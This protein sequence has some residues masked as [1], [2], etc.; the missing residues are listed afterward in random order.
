MRLK[1]PV[2][3]F[4]GAAGG[5][6]QSN[7]AS[8]SGVISDAQGAVMQG[9]RVTMINAQT[10]VPAHAASN[11]AGFYAIPNL[12]VGTYTLTVEREGFRRYVREG[13]ALSTGQTLGLDVKM[14]VGALAETVTVSGD[15]PLVETRTSD[16]TQLIEAKSIAD[17]PLGNRHT[18]N[19][20]NLTGAAVFVTYPNAPGNSNPSFTLAG[21]RPQ[22]QMFWIDGGSG[23]N[24]RLGAGQINL[25]PPVDTV[26]EIKVLSNN[27]SA[28]YGGSAGGIIVET[29]RS[30]T[31][32]LHGSA[33]EYLRNNAMDAPGFFAPVQNGAK[34]TP[35]LRYNVF[36]GTAGGPVRRDKTFFFA[37]Y[38]GQ[39]LRTGG[40]D[41]LTVPTALQRAGDFSQTFNAAGKVIPIYDPATSPR[42]QFPGNVIP[43]TRLDAVGVKILSFYPQANRAADNATGA[44]NFRANYVSGTPADFYMGKIDHN[45]S[46]RDR[47]TGRY[48]RNGGTNFNTSAFPDAGADPR[49]HAENQQQ[50]VYGNWTRTINPTSVNDF[51]FTYIYRVFHDLSAG[52]GGGYPAKMGL[53]GVPD[54]AFPRF[55]IAGFSTLGTN[56]QERR[57]FPIEQQQFVDNFSKVKG[58]HALKF[59]FEARRSRNHEFNLPTV[60]GDF[61]FATQPT[62]LAGN[63]ATGYGLASLLLGFPSNFAE[64]QT[65]ELDRSS[66]YL[67]AFA[68]DDWTVSP[69]LTV[70]LGLRWE[71]DTPIVD[72]RNRMNGFDPAQINPVSGTPGVVK[73]M[74]VN[75]FRTTPYDL[76]WNNFGPRFGFAWKPFGASGTVIRGGYGIFYAHPFDSGQPNTAALGFSTS[77]Q[78]STP[79]NGITAPFFLRDGVPALPSAPLL[80]DS[81]GAAPLGKAVNTAVTYYEASRATGYAQQFNLG[82]QHELPVQSV[83]ELTVLGNLSRKLANANLPLAQIP[84][85]ILGPA[86]QS[87]VDRP[88]PQFNGVTIIAPPLG[89]SNYY[90]G[91]LR[92]QKRYAHGLNLGGSYT[93]AK[94]L[95]NTSDPGSSLGA[96]A[97]PYSDFYNRRAD[98]GYGQ[99]DIRHRFSFN[100]VYELPFGEGRHWL[101]KG[102]AGKIVG[103]WSLANVTTVQSGPPATVTTQT[104]TTNAFSAGAQRADVSRDPNL[105]PGSRTVAQWFDTAAFTQPAQFHFGNQGVGLV[106]GP[107][108][109]NV[110]FSL[111]RELR[112]SERMRLQ[113]RGE[114]I[115]A[116]NRTNLGVPGHTFGAPGFGVISGLSLASSPRQVQVGARIAF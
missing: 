34:V 70:N 41:A 7:L 82:V 68:Q 29:T 52:L 100:A 79:D 86:H 49:N 61:S 84:P 108:L 22:S 114:F 87:Q 107:G 63:A 3:L 64:N 6:A 43:P 20:I 25:D 27:N 56:A 1:I 96:N 2:L 50:Y 15:V 4:L 89:V 105:A 44:N 54:N 31:N 80:N 76:D 48:L 67:A 42:T 17:L 12:A 101:G 95:D 19:V 109:I 73:F 55:T 60:S 78:L 39:R 98:Y 99:N 11:D 33:Y 113:L 91:L 23:Q 116:L 30:G 103:D 24:M 58:R 35:E 66:W 83:V 69:S 13:M 90:A 45:L 38:E 112:F 88:F 94:F 104:N 28:E 32:H 16:V 26:E 85:Q 36:G 5:L 18:L 115:N 97:G 71:V 110:D 9:A 102:A 37:A 57:Q 106:R 81:Y 111:Q 53:K 47:L 93:L 74:G 10:G 40:T 62:G 8:V 21:G 72:A 65:A 59:G 92:F 77:A 46:D 14:E 51:R 75:R